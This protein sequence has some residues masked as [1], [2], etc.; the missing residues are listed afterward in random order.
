MYISVIGAGECDRR[1]RALAEE[2]GR[3]VAAAGAVLVC[4]GLGGVMDAA[5]SGARESGGIAV[6]ILPFEDRQGASPHLTVSLPTDLGHARNAV[7]V[8]CAD[9]VIAIG[10]GYGT[11]SEIG[12]ALKMGKP[13]V[14]LGTWELG[15]DGHPV[16]A[17]RYAKTA[18][19]A[20][21]LAVAFSGARP[22]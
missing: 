8:R 6:G 17:I 1:T 21:D 18:R 22:Q 2:V 3:E 11:L 13:V 15:R 7:V 14:G 16:E 4:G 20:V 9:A 5:A 19:E 10:G 12:L